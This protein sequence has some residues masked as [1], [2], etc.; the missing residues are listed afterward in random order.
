M[1]ATPS[2]HAPHRLSRSAGGGRSAAALDVAGVRAEQLPP[3]ISRTATLDLSTTMAARVGLRAGTPVVVGAG[4]GPLGNLGTGALEPGVVGRLFC[5]ALTDDAWVVGGA[6]SNGGV[7]VRWA[8]DVFGS[9]L[10]PGTDGA[11]RDAELLALAHAVPPG[12]DGLVMLPDLLAERAPL[13]DPDLTGAYLGIRHA[14]TRGH[15]VRAAVEGVAFQLSAI[16]DELDRPSSRSRRS[17]R[18][19]VRSVRPCGA[20]SWPRSS[21]ARCG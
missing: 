4:D 8:G 9:D 18:P 13:W 14:H 21:R 12:S 1:T 15:F 6:V 20:R 5:C 10:R 19:A 11:P 17:A 16:V 7:V 3:I 2:L